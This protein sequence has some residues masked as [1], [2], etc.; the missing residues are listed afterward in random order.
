MD[1]SVI[2]NR[3]GIDISARMGKSA[4][5]DVEFHKY[6]NVGHNFGL[7]QTLRSDWKTLYD[8]EKSISRRLCQNRSL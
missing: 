3:N 6:L 2:D 8:F 7:R 1:F 5:L 4:G